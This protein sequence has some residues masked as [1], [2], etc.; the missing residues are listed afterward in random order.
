[1]MKFIEKVHYQLL[2]HKI[3]AAKLCDDLGIA[4]T[5]VDN[6]A[7]RSGFPEM[8]TLLKLAKYFNVTIEYLVDE[9]DEEIKYSPQVVEKLIPAKI[10]IV[11]FIN[12]IRDFSDVEMANIYNYAASIKTNRN[13]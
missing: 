3:T 13:R 2:T 12:Y 11:N 4:V 9:I 7:R 6:W 5:S 1:M 10:H 8:K